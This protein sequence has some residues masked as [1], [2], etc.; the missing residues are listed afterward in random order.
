M[1]KGY[2]IKDFRLAT[3]GEFSEYGGGHGILAG[4]PRG[5]SPFVVYKFLKEHFGRP[6]HIQPDSSR[7]T[8]E[9]V[10]KGPRRYL[11]VYDWKFHSW[12]IGIRLPWSFTEQKIEVEKIDK[13]DEEARAD[14]N[15]LLEEIAKYAKTIEIPKTKHSYQ[16]IENTFKISY[17]YGEHFLQSIDQP[18]DT[19]VV[20]ILAQSFSH[21]VFFED[22]SDAWAAI[23]SFL[24]SVEALFNILFE[25]YLKKEIR[26][27]EVLRQHIFRLP[28]LDK[29]LL[30]AS[31]CTCFA[32][33]PN[34]KSRGYQSLKRLIRIRN[35]WAHATV[36]D[37]MRIFFI[38][39]DDLMFAT[40]SLPIYRERERA[41]VCPRMSS[42][43]Y[44]SAKK[45]KDDVDAIKSKIL[46]AMKK[47]DRQKFA[48]ALEEQY[49]LLSRK[50]SLAL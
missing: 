32:K 2:S 41:Y 48:K 29:W 19:P 20:P 35:D 14:A 7:I 50:G 26:E 4:S 39:E 44:T 9:Y 8:W 47:N 30:S 17:W 43:D 46:D 33:Q 31:L 42:L 10:L 27:D 24:L 28:L 13:Y 1:K 37:E 18:R 15:I 49:I 22:C 34:R 36:S 12:G 40:R 11:A 3:P 45:V 25:I 21:L 6:S 38:Q 5:I 16:L 23:M